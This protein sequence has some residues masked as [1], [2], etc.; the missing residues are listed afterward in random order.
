MS[1]AKSEID[2]D[3]DAPFE[4]DKLDREDTA[5]K[6]TSLMLSFEDSLVLSI[7]GRWGAGKTT[8]IKMWNH[9]LENEDTA[10]SLRFNA[11]ENDFA[12]DPALVFI[13]E[14]TEAIE[15]DNEL[16]ADG[17]IE[18]DQLRVIG[19]EVIPLLLELSIGARTATL[20]E[21]GIDAADSLFQNFEE[22]KSQI[23][24]FK[25]ELKGVA[26]QIQKETSAPLV[27]FVDELDRCRPD[28]AVELLER[29]KHLFDVPGIV[30]VLAVDAEQL[31]NS[32]RSLY[33]REMDAEGH[34][35][36][37][38]D[39]SYRLP[40]P[41]D[42]EYVQ[43]LY[44]RHDTDELLR[45]SDV[46]LAMLAVAKQCADHYDL[47]L[48]AKE[49]L[50]LR[51]DLTFR[52]LNSGLGSMPN[53]LYPAVPFLVALRMER[54]DAYEKLI[55]GKS[56]EKSIEEAEVFTTGALETM[57]EGGFSRPNM[58]VRPQY[59]LEAVNR[60]IAAGE[61][62]FDRT[63]SKIGDRMEEVANEDP[64]EWEGPIHEKTEL[65]RQ[66][67]GV[68]K[69]MREIDAHGGAKVVT[70]LVD[71]IELSGQLDQV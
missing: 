12:S 26:E 31:A 61:S 52:Q 21:K 13:N 49:Q 50:M 2:I 9:M 47:S 42:G 32:V 6:L 35:R 68:L 29:I 62:D 38:I 10:K 33:G 8:F 51:L 60:A 24:Q 16:S 53:F 4:N 3:P 45:G 28:F 65:E 40:R 70:Q 17:G 55:R 7:N 5:R 43:Y 14:M 44:S 66:W 56:A 36:R 54:K 30:F 69:T 63:L 27:V 59:F 37:F 71:A 67:K 11:W 25:E 18:T 34:L 20:A 57:I 46:I 39:L 41:S 23:H 19:K 48:R 64:N 22:A 58:S 15:D 1:V